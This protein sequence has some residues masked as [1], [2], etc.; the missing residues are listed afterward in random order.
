MAGGNANCPGVFIDV[1]RERRRLREVDKRSVDKVVVVV[2]Y[3]PPD[4]TV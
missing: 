2:V 4:R 1:F 3:R